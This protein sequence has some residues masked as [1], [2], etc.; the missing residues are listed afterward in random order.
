[1]SLNNNS[2]WW[3]GLHTVKV[4]SDSSVAMTFTALVN[5]ASEPTQNY[6]KPVF[7]SER[8]QLRER[9]GKYKRVQ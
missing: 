7:Y 4:I 2:V 3:Y 8:N 6:F 9:G 5:S 1:M